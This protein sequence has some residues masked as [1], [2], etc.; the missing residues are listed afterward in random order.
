MSLNKL[1]HFL[2]VYIFIDRLSEYTSQNI[3]P[4][5]TK[6]TNNL[7]ISPRDAEKLIKELNLKGFKKTEI[8][9]EV[10]EPSIEEKVEIEDD[11][12]KY[13]IYSGPQKT[14]S[15]TVVR[16]PVELK[17]EDTN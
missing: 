1:H 8:P 3:R 10:E 11:M 7:G 16:K 2:Q 4:P 14:I 17:D 5:I 6:V 13:S 12:P 15:S 9:E